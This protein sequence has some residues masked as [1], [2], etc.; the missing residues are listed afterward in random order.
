[1]T[2]TVLT[3]S[4]G[5]EQGHRRVILAAALGTVFEWYDF[6]LYGALAATLSR[7]FFSAVS[8]GT[9]FIFALLA[10][11]AG[12]AV[13]PVGALIFGRMGDIAGRKYT[14]LIT[15]TLMGLSTALVGALPTYARIGIAAPVLL[16]SLRIIQGLALGGEYGGAAVYVAEHVP[17]EKRGYYTGW[18]NGTAT[19]G[20][21]LSLAVILICRAVFD[22]RFEIWGW[23]V[24]FLV[25]LVLLSISLYVRLKLAESP[26]FQKMRAEGT[27]SRTPVADSLF[28]WRNL[29]VILAA[30]FGQCAGL[31]VIFYT[32]H[33]YALFFLTQV[34][35]V[36]ARSAEFV[37]LGVLLLAVP[38]Y[39]FAGAISDRIGRKPLIVG[40]CLAAAITFIPIFHGL[41]HFA[42]PALEAAMAENPISVIADPATCRLQ[43]DP[44]GKATF[45][46][47]CDIAKAVLTKRGA[48]YANENGAAG[49]V[50]RVRIGGRALSAFEGASLQA[51]ELGLRR[52][53]FE[54]ELD[55]A[56]A[57]AHYPGKAD[58]GRVQY[59][60]LVALLFM[61]LLIAGLTYGPS[62][63]WL[64]ELFPAR[65]RYTSLS[66][67]YHF[68]VGW[69]GGFLPAIAFMLVAASGDIY[70]GLWYPV[71]VCL[72]AAL[73]SGL[74]LPETSGPY[75]RLRP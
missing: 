24:P 59:V 7:Q 50:A 5:I 45:L 35:K 4:L 22:E 64:T 53:Q 60:P 43:F 69:F 65:I 39:A 75:P 56:L 71:G 26:V 58:P 34:L 8:P 12:F 9:G 52:A 28:N 29:R 16:V 17:D 32:A 41:T 57:A 27:H 19:M 66:V 70:R 51:Q 1:M 11:A 31:T 20:F 10:F 63:A 48:P 74:L 6:F 49:S 68:A 54:A 21:V 73:I 46:S 67:P 44:V 23:R 42:N 62:A 18:I 61:L 47:S 14:F 40:G 25:S 15:I 13:R 72:V 33:F 55:T 37:M 2:S 36:G 38:L 30:L 3:G